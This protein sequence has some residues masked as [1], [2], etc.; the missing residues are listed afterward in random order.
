[1]SEDYL[2]VP[3]LSARLPDLPDDSILSQTL[4]S[5]DKVKVV[6]FGFAPGQSLSE[7]TAS[8][9]AIVQVLKGKGSIELAGDRRDLDP[10]SWIYMP[11][12]LEHSLHAEEEMV[13]LLYLLHS[14]AGGQAD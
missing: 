11:A 9:P 3:N 5:T 14:P 2:Y 7:H 1:M 6:L 8:V 10:G 13:V 12:R 4:H